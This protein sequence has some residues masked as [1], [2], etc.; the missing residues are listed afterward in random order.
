MALILIYLN[1]VWCFSFTCMHHHLNLSFIFLKYF[2]TTY[3]K[4][5]TISV[6]KILRNFESASL[7][8]FRTKSSFIH[9]RQWK[10]FE[11][12][13]FFI[14]YCCKVC[15]T[16]ALVFLWLISAMIIGNNCGCFTLEPCR[17]RVCF[18]SLDLFRQ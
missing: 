7:P 12:A 10:S 1:N 17:I 2:I 15:D 13:V 9:I 4:S 3:L 8:N 14:R 6:C 18:A 16:K 5:F 11:H